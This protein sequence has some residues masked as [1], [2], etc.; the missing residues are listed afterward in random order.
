MAEGTPRE[1]DRLQINLMH[2]DAKASTLKLHNA[3]TEILT[4]K[5]GTHAWAVRT[6]EK[7]AELAVSKKAEESYRKE[8]DDHLA[9]AESGGHE[10]HEHS[11]PSLPTLGACSK[12]DHPEK[13]LLHVLM[14]YK[15]GRI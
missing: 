14:Y 9:T 12:P 6:R 5:K 15:K 3:Q 7:D 11:P 8:R 1:N 13:K 10:G 2:R 4:L